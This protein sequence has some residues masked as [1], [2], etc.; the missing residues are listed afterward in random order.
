MPRE[1]IC[2][3]RIHLLH[4]WR[5]AP[6]TAIAGLCG[7]YNAHLIVDEAHA[8]GIIGPRGEGLVQQLE[9]TDACFARIHTFGKAV[10][11]H[12]AV[13]LGSEILRDYLI[14]F[15]R[16]F[17]YTT[18]LP[19]AALA[20]IEAGYSAFPYMQEERA[21]LLALIGQFQ[22]GLSHVELLAGNTPIQAVLTRGN[23]NTRK[24]AATLQA[25][26]LDVRPILHPTVPKGAERLRI[27]LHSFNTQD[28]VARLIKV[29]QA[30][31]DMNQI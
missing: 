21:H 3:G 5:P 8:T 13:V 24:I 9:L 10:G 17:I 1:Y 19:P 4:G 28:E 7:Q 26:G 11:C 12:G 16:S 30:E 2:C 23:D 29:L 31:A 27:V 6:L 18:A 15:S 22:A 14:N 25:A 20:A